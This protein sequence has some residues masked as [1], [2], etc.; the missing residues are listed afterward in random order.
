M[1]PD[2]DTMCSLAM[3]AMSMYLV[4]LPNRGLSCCGYD[5]HILIGCCKILPQI[6]VYLCTKTYLYP[7]CGRAMCHSTV[8]LRVTAVRQGSQAAESK[9][10]CVCVCTWGTL[11]V[12]PSI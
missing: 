3:L 11:Y 12:K 2:G 4:W 7:R 8:L 10:V 1:N 6:F 9:C 5:C